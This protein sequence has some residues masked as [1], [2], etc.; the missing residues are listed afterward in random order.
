MSAGSKFFGND[1]DT[2]RFFDSPSKNV[3]VLQKMGLAAQKVSDL[4]SFFVSH[5]SLQARTIGLTHSYS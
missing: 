3:L 5:I 2:I 4:A 1:N